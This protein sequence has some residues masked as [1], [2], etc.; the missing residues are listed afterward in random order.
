MVLGGADGLEVLNRTLGTGGKRATNSA[1]PPLELYCIARRE[2]SL[3][4][5]DYSGQGTLDLNNSNSLKL[6]VT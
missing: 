2:H 1:T 5:M 6:V 3:E 4:Q